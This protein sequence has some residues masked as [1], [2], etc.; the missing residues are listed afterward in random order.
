MLPPERLIVRAVTGDIR[1]LSN[2]PLSSVKVRIRL[3]RK[4][5]GQTLSEDD[6]V[7]SAI[8]AIPPGEQRE[9]ES[10]GYWPDL[11]IPNSAFGDW[12]WEWSLIEACNITD[13][14]A[15]LRPWRP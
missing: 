2:V 6:V 9:V 10:R 7:L 13:V 3:F 5:T 12:G 1:N 8:P 14:Q 15:R 11:I 4:S